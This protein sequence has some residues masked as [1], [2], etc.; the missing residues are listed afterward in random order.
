MLSRCAVCKKTWRIKAFPR[1]A[2]GWDTYLQGL[3]ENTSAREIEH[4]Y[5]AEKA[6]KKKDEML[7]I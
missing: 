4:L 5:E 7:K 1:S 2:S 3:A 6:W